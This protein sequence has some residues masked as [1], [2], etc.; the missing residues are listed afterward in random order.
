MDRKRFQLYS[1]DV[2]ET[3]FGS[4]TFFKDKFLRLR[5]FYSNFVDLRVEALCTHG[6]K[7]FSITDVKKK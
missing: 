1:A 3:K 6:S 5:K 2:K 7:L 4:R